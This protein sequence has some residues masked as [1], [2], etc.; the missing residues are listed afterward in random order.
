MFNVIQDDQR[1]SKLRIKE[2]K[3]KNKLNTKNSNIKL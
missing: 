3:E 2:T 1:I